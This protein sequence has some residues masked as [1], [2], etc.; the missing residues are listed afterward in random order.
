MDFDW[1]ALV[2]T[3][4]PAIASVFGT[5]LA[6]MG[7]TAILNAVLPEGEA[8]PAKPEEYLAKVLA[9]ANPD[10]MLKLKTAEQQFTL[11][12]KKLDIDLEKYLEQLELESVKGAQDLK[13]HWLLSG[14]FDYEPFL[15][16][17]V[18]GAFGYAEWWVFAH[19]T[20]T[21]MDP[22]A[23]VLIGRVLGTVDAAFMLLLGFRWGTSHDSGRKT[24]II[25]NGNGHPK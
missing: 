21:G 20:L 16:I 24:E 14:K 6:G 17:G 19:A 8:P 1:K 25:A 22:G 12:I 18:F 15:A 13:K 5:P 11:D 10:I 3:V 4:A 2:R 23:S 9:N 7:V